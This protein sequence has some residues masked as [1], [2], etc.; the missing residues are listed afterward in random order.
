VAKRARGA[1]VDR[2]P[3][4]KVK[5][6]DQSYSWKARAGRRGGKHRWG[7]KNQEPGKTKTD[8]GRDMKVTNRPWKSIRSDIFM[9]EA[10]RRKGTQDYKRAIC[11]GR[12]HPVPG[13]ENSVARR[14]S[15]GARMS[16]GRKGRGWDAAV[17]AS[18]NGRPSKLK[19]KKRCE[20]HSTV[21]RERE[22]K[23]RIE[24]EHDKSR[25][26]EKCCPLGR[27]RRR[28][29]CERRKR[30]KRGER[31]ISKKE[32]GSPSWQRG[33]RVPEKELQMTRDGPVAAEKRQGKNRKSNHK[34]NHMLLAGAPSGEK[35]AGKIRQL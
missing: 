25:G 33:E 6:V 31:R 11:L 15:K 18:N 24:L 4:G 30:D 29:E 5:E 16:K 32:Q 12:S 17:R 13:S 7:E 19:G 20:S 10:S 35:L 22:E 9:R 26:K 23:T 27:W 14:R 2:K 21:Q 3:L 34:K 28:E 1:R 8:R